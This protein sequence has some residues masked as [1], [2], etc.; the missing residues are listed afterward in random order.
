[1][2]AN[3]SNQ[4]HNYTQRLLVI[5]SASPY[6]THNLLSRSIPLFSIFTLVGS[7][8]SNTRQA[9]V[10]IDKEA[11]ILQKYSYEN[12]SS[13]RS[14]LL[15]ILYADFTE[16]LSFSPSF[17]THES[18]LCRIGHLFSSK[19]FIC[20][21]SPTSYSNIVLLHSKFHVHWLLFQPPI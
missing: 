3:A 9:T 12:L 16:Y 4:P 21:S 15:R 10:C 5:Y 19:C 2:V 20:L 18:L 13:P 1:M 6:R 11:L 8:S 14:S 17:Q 7:L